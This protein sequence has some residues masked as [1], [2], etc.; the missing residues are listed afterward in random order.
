MIV[1]RKS[2]D[3]G[4]SFLDWLDSYHTFSFAEY[5]DRHWMEFGSLR[6]I[7]EDTIQPGQ[8]FGMHPHH[9]MEIITYVVQGALE[10]RDSMGNSSIIRPGEIQRMS[11]GTGVRH[12]ELNHSQTE[13]LH[14]LQIWIMPE[15]KGIQPDY[16]QKPIQKKLNQLTLLAS[17]M[18]TPDAVMLHQNMHLYVGYFHPNCQFNYSLK[19]SYSWLQLIKGN[20]G[21]NDQIMRPGDGAA[22]QNEKQ[23]TI[24]C[25]D[26]AEFLFFESY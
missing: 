16:E 10:H 22:I 24:E 26:E 25:Q 23:I 7:N 3:R 9:D 12:S 21:L 15:R 1:I 2:K 13:A 18:P 5:Y 17:P 4:K 20:I 8:G 11:A 6:V 14:L 19:S